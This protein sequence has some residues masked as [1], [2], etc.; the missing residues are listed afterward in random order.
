[1]S[2]ES[3]LM[4]AGIINEVSSG[5]SVS[6]SHD[7]PD[8]RRTKRPRLDLEPLVFEPEL[9]RVAEDEALDPDDPL[10]VQPRRELSLLC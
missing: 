9:L 1:M 5:V 2:N 7:A 3:G 8:Q 4:S 10:D 6:I